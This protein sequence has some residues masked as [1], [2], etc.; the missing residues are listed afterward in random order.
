MVAT[1]AHM[2]IVRFISGESLGVFGAELLSC[3]LDELFLHVYRRLVVPL[4]PTVSLVSDPN[5]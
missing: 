5:L 1:T 3:F 4:L 2:P